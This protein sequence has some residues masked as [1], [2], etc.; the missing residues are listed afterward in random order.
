MFK[1]ERAPQKNQATA[2]LVA[3][4]VISANCTLVAAKEVLDVHSTVTAMPVHIFA[5]TFKKSLALVDRQPATPAC[6]TSFDILFECLPL[7]LH[8]FLDGRQVICCFCYKP[9]ETVDN[10]LSDSLSL[11]AKR[12]WK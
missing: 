1:V 3:Q 6:Q 4:P 9:R 12:R 5:Q 11:A 8:L 7:S 10:V 2:H